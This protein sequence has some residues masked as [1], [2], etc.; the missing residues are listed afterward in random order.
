ML[1]FF[2]MR[3]GNHNLLIKTKIYGGAKMKKVWKQQ[4]C[5]G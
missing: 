4:N 2:M 5:Y 3:I 1:I